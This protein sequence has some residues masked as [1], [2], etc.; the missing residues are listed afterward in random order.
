MHVL[1]LLSIQAR[2]FIDLQSL[3]L[4]ADK[5]WTPF[6]DISSH[7]L[8]FSRRKSSEFHANCF[9]S[10]WHAF[11]SSA[12]LLQ[13][14]IWDYIFC[15]GTE[16]NP[17]CPNSSQLLQWHIFKPES[18]RWNKDHVGSKHGIGSQAAWASPGRASMAGIHP[19][20]KELPV[21]RSHPSDPG[22]HICACPQDKL[23]ATSG[24]SQTS[25]WLKIKP[26]NM[27]PGNSWPFTNFL[28]Q[29]TQPLY[30]KQQEVVGDF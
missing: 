16:S 25:L 23:N 21:V 26:K 6:S 17:R 4:L 13:L 11:H 19:K 1:L 7:A 14:R 24:R 28:K 2:L 5:R 18:Q 10:Q 12:H 27:N 15:I 22:W 8:V 3:L 20:C 9:L 29:W 30:E